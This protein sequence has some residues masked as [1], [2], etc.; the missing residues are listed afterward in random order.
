MNKEDCQGDNLSGPQI[1]NPDLVGPQISNPIYLRE[2]CWPLPGGSCGKPTTRNF[3]GTAMPY[4]L[5]HSTKAYY[6]FKAETSHVRTPAELPDFN[7]L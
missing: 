7:D 3:R 4:C 6:N 1:S 5:E 2:C